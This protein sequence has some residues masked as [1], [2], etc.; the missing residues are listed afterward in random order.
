MIELKEIDLPIGTRFI[1]RN[2]QLEVVES[3]KC[4]GCYYYDNNQGDCI[5]GSLNCFGPFRVD[6]KSVLFKQVGTIKN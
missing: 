6:H 2:V 4:A 5:S 1:T 3:D